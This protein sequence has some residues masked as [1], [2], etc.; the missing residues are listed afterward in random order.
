[1]QT[2]F[3][4]KVEEAIILTDMKASV[5]RYQE[6]VDNAKVRLNLA[7]CLG[8]WLMPGRM[9]INTESVVGYN[10]KLQQA[11][12][13]MKLEINDWVNKTRKKRPLDPWMA[14]NQRLTHQTA[15]LLIRYTTQ[16]KRRGFYPLLTFN[17]NS[18]FLSCFTDGAMVYFCTRF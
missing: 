3:L 1:M 5:G 12:V 2:Q 14:G 7:V 9:F 18:I 10:N 6:A 8:A 13:G 16:Q 15:T 4:K 11:N 17:Y